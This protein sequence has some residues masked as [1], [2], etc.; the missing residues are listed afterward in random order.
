MQSL[1]ETTARLRLSRLEHS[2]GG[3]M[4]GSAL[5]ETADFGP[6]PGALR[7]F[8]YRPD[9]WKPGAALVVVLHGCTQFAS[10][11]AA[12]G[13]WLRMADRCGFAVLAPEQTAANNPARCFNW[14]DGDDISR[15]RGEAASIV[16]MVH[17]LV[18][19]ASLDPGRVFVVGLSAGGAMTA[20]LLAAYPE[21][22][23]GGAIVAGL[24]AGVAGNLTEAMRLM[25]HGDSRSGA[26]LAGLIPRPSPALPRLS[27]W[28]GDADLVVNPLNAGAIVRQWAAARG[29]AETPDETE[30]LGR[31]A[32]SIWRSRQ[33]GGVVLEL[34]VVAGLGHGVPLATREDGAVGAAAPVMLE[35]G[36]SSTRE[37]A[38]FWGLKESIG[39]RAAVHAGT[40]S[41]GS[42]RFGLGDQLMRSVADRVPESV[43]E[44][45][46]KALRS[47]GLLK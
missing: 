35:V 21:V 29:L 18:R 39:R 34:N 15:D 7:M 45:I 9:G 30:R 43:R 14:F 10:A 31:R 25:H 3:S 28:Q 4:G 44:V 1:G 8:S 33:G 40:G 5:L 32:R 24:P 11:F 37:I 23:V 20:G 27:I 2:V 16:A 42:S 17:W 6:N 26:D 46:A 47:A 12:D 38:A 41:C 19:E 13:G 36:I 22:F